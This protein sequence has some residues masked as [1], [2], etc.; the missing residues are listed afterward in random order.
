[1]CSVSCIRDSAEVSFT[2]ALLLFHEA[3]TLRRRGS[4][5]TLPASFNLYLNS[6]RL[7]QALEI[8]GWASVVIKQNIENRQIYFFIF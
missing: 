5:L 1:M 6:F 7:K 3:L 8:K 2:D 4:I